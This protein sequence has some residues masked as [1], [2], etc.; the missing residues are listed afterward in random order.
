MTNSSIHSSLYKFNL[1]Y[2]YITLQILFYCY[3]TSRIF[4]SLYI[5]SRFLLHFHTISWFLIQFQK[6]RDFSKNCYIIFLKFSSFFSIFNKVFNDKNIS[7]KKRNINNNI[8]GD[9]NL[10]QLMIIILIIIEVHIHCHW[11]GRRN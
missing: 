2:F 10:S 4:F 3:F 11:H 9:L 7:N 8:L 1:L 6:N 5:H